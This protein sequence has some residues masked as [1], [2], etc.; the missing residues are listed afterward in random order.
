MGYARQRLAEQL[1]RRGAH[2]ERILEA[3]EVLDPEALT[4]AFARRFATY[5]RATLLTLDL[6]R[7][8]RVLNNPQRPVQII[9]SGKAHP[10]D[11][12]G[13]E[14]IQKIIRVSN[15]PRFRRRFVFLEDYD[16]RVAR[17][18]VQGADVWLNT[19]R[20]P[21][22]A[23]GTSGMKAVMNGGLHLSVLDGWWVEGYQG[24]NGWA[25]GAG[26]EYKDTE[27]QDR[28]ESMLL[29]EMLEDAVSPLFY[30]RGQDGL[31]RDWIAM[32]KASM[33][34][35]CAVF[36]TNRMVEEYVEKAYLPSAM[37]WRVLTDDDFARARDVAEWRRRVLERWE[38]VAVREVQTE[39]R[40]ELKVGED[41][42]VRVVVDLGGL[43]TEDVA[44]ELYYGPIDAKRLIVDGRVA[45][46]RPVEAVGGTLHRYEGGVRSGLGPPRLHRA[47][48]PPS[49][50]HPAR[51]G[52]GVVAW[53]EGVLRLSFIVERARVRPRH[54]R[55]GNERVKPRRPGRGCV[56]AG[57]GPSPGAAGPA[58]RPPGAGR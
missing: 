46:M 24:D 34:S 58:S 31:P 18:L 10:K 3:K 49:R 35:L 16:I 5:K 15:D 32:M 4:I 40:E 30:R 20:R 1:Q 38:G 8:D 19:P 25:I 13:K 53:G 41:L 36:N 42:P 43:A 44:V 26:E 28:I 17:Y 47:R 29:F 7:L 12:P 23:S 33:R 45:G 9:M 51:R 11:T 2:R 39:Q 52:T 57:R 50:R 48:P 14:M 27:E 54:G 56:A 21:L 22:E 55:G 6:D 37:A